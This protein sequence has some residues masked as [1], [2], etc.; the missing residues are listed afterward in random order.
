LEQLLYCEQYVFGPSLNK[1]N[2]GD[3]INIATPGNKKKKQKL[4]YMGGKWVLTN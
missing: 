1:E 3:L 2:L 4:R